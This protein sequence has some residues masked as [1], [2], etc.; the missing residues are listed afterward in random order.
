M[1]PEDADSLRDLQ[2]QSA[3][4][5]ALGDLSNTAKSLDSACAMFN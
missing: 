1:T 4:S 2:A 5:L 3:T